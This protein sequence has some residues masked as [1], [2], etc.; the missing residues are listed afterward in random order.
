[1]LFLEEAAISLRETIE[2]DIPSMIY[3]IESKKFPKEIKN[4]SLAH[5]V[6]IV[7]MKLQGF[8]TV[9][10]FPYSHATTLTELNSI[11][12]QCSSETLLCVGGADN[13]NLLLVSC[14]NCR[15]VLT[16]TPRNHSVLNNGA[17]WYLT[18]SYSFGFSPIYNI[19][20]DPDQDTFDSV[21]DKTFPD[22]NRLSWIMYDGK[23]GWRLGDL[24]DKAGTTKGLRKIMMLD[25]TSI[26]PKSN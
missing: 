8:K 14:G 24:N 16:P 19:K 12:S 7:D 17:Y 23:G 22:Q 13:D 10:D 25:S 3:K 1:M 11:K 6:S 2:V 26:T 21:L 9:Y 20:L 15:A 18:N 5:D 4:Y